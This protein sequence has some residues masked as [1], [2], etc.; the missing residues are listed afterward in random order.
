MA[1]FDKT[2]E[3]PRQKFKEILKKTEIKPAQG[4]PLS[5]RQRVDLGQKILR[6]RVGDAISKSEYSRTL[7][8]LRSEKINEQDFA[9]KYKMGK[10]IKFLQELEKK[11]D[12][13]K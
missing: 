13:P 2:P 3:I 8:K 4:R 10:E 9:K 6:G 11:P 7:N 5:E 12:L 1:L